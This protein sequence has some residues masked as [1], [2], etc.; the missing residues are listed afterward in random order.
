MSLIMAGCFGPPTMESCDLALCYR[1]TF[2]V[3]VLIFGFIAKPCELFDVLSTR[4]IVPRTSRDR[5]SPTHFTC[6]SLATRGSLSIKCTG[7]YG[8]RKSAFSKVTS[9]ARNCDEALVEQL[10]FRPSV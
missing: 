4:R 9:L 10:L 1:A 8:D 2:K 3:A 6:R 5:L 7:I